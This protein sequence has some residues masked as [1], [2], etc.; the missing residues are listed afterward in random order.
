M[1]LVETKCSHI[2][3]VISNM[4]SKM[5]ARYRV[6]QIQNNGVQII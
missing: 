3:Q 5:S 4:V 1:D 6:R 2:Q